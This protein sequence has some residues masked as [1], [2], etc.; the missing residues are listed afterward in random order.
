MINQNIEFNHLKIAQSSLIL[1]YKN[2]LD[3]DILLSSIETL[4][5]MPTKTHNYLKTTLILAV[6]SISITLLISNYSMSTPYFIASVL[7]V[8]EIILATK[9][10]FYTLTI[11]LKNGNHYTQKI[12]IS[13]KY[14]TVSLIQKIKKEIS[15]QKI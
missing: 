2:N 15:S 3:T 7:I 9:S 12:P 8:F 14:K 1:C 13:N 10:K 5:M 11:Y 6:Y 4:Y